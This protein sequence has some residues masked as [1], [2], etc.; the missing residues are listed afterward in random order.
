MSDIRAL[1]LRLLDQIFEMQDGYVLDFSNQTISSFFIEEL[2]LDIYDP[3]YSAEGNSKAKRLRYLLRKVDNSTAARVIKS[4]WQYRQGIGRTALHNES[5]IEGRILDLLGRLDGTLSRPQQTP[6]SHSNKLLLE[7]LGR[8]LLA[9]WEYEPHARGYAFEELLKS[10]FNLYGLKAKSPFRL[11]G[12]QIDGSF[13]I[14][15]STYLLEAKWEATPTSAA[16]LHTF[17]GKLGQKAAWARG[18]FVSYSGFTNEG[19]HAFGCSKRIVCMS[20]QDIAEAIKRNLPLDH[21]IRQKVRKAAE[22]GNCFT[23]VRDLIDS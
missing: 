12:E 15:N 10:M 7:R 2:N 13:E 4:L 21:V 11:R 14:D 3:Q 20:G 5:Q 9:I 19:L 17:E 1:D 6:P 16:D 23:P 18:L 8:E 22:T